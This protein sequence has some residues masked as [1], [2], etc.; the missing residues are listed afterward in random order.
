[1]NKRYVTKNGL[2]KLRQDL[3]E[4]KKKRADIVERIK[5][6]KELGDLR[7]NAEYSEARDAQAFNEA[8]ILEL[9]DMLKNIEVVENG[10]GS[11]VVVI[12]SVITVESQGKVQDFELVG[13][14]EA[15]PLE[16]KISVESPLGQA[17]MGRKKNEEVT[18]S[19]PK[20]DMQYKILKIK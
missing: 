13:A 15:K 7:E 5:T 19:V 11:D 6:A 1:M 3:E 17:F 14:S 9:E 12:G 2:E 10:S 18:V 4:L 8:K 16:G 20:G